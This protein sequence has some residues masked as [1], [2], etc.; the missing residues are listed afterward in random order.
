MLC[1]TGASLGADALEPITLTAGIG[2]AT[3]LGVSTSFLGYERAYCKWFECCTDDWVTPNI[4]ALHKSFQQRLYGQHLVSERL[5]PA[6]RSHFSGARPKKALAVSLHGMTGSGKNFVSGLVAEH[7]FKLGMASQDVHLLVGTLHFPH[8]AQLPL[9]KEQVR[10]WIRGNVTR[11]PRSVF[12]LDEMDKM[13]NG[14]VDALTPFLDFHE[15]VDGVDYRRATFLLLSNAGAAAINQFVLDQWQAGRPRHKLGYAEME[16]LL[17]R[18]AFNSQGG[19]WRADLIQRQLV[20]AFIPFLPLERAHVR[21][22][23]KHELRA[24]AAAAGVELDQ[25]SRLVEKVMD[26]LM[27]FPADKKLFSATGCKRV[28][29]RVNFVWDQSMH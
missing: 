10:D 27:F 26:E 9:Y 17:T 3:A 11:C 12:I 2:I 23:I 8:A 4:S 28:A 18:S 16:A 24:K 5:I 20:S 1:F 19:L 13:P 25:E 14:L 6:L 15:T 22:C 21:A 7:L 29:D